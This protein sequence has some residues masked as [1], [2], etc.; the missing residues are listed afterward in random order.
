[1][2]WEVRTMASGT[3]YFNCT[4]YRKTMGRFWPLW[5]LWGVLWML[6][7]P[8]NG[9]SRYID[10]LAWGENANSLVYH[11]T[12]I[13][14]SRSFGVWA[15][16]LFGLLAAMAAFSYLYSQ[17]SAC[18]MHALPIRREGL[19]FSQYLA[20]LT[21]LLLP[22]AVVALAALGVELAV[23][24]SWGWSQT[25]PA[26]GL[27]L[28]CMGGISLFFYSFACFCAMFT[29]HLLALP[30]FYGILNVLASGV[31]FL[32]VALMQQFLYGFQGRGVPLLVELAT[33]LLRLTG[34]CGVYTSSS[35][36]S[37]GRVHILLSL[38]SPGD[39]AGYAAAGVALAL[40]ALW[41]YKSRQV[42][43]AGDVVSVPL[44]RPV[45][46]YGVAFC[47]G[48]CLGV[49]TVSLLGW[50][51]GDSAAVLVAAILLWTAAGFFAAE[52]LLKKTF[53][54]FRAWRGCVASVAVMAFL[55][56]VCV[57]DLF[58]VETRLPSLEQVVRM[59]VD[60]DI[61]YPADSGRL[62]AVTGDPAVIQPVLELQRAIV[63]Q[64]GRAGTE[65]GDD[66][67]SL[68]V[69]Y[70]LNGGGT[71]SRSYFSVPVFREELE[72]EGS[73]TWQAARLLGDR[74]LT[75][76][77][78][79][80][81]RCEEGRLAE[82]RLEDVLD[83]REGYGVSLYLEQSTAELLELWQ[84]VRQDFQEGNLGAHTLFLPE[85]PEDGL[86]TSTGWG[87]WPSL[88]FYWEME[89]DSAQA[90]GEASAAV[91]TQR[92]EIALSPQAE[93]TLAWMEAHH[94]PGEGYALFWD[95]ET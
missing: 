55:C 23:V 69:T 40:L 12:D 58:G 65:A 89:A 54:V 10:W 59:E 49:F 42:E 76:Q 34:A 30:V 60:A 41:V 52:M 90:A 44:V 57:F 35:T 67:I 50:S 94:V 62:E 87:M 28:A 24:P 1:M 27:W 43:S 46:K 45:F 74:A 31:N 56:A 47:A 63:E 73:V 20:G 71:M 61:G 32:V 3:S 48:L 78:Y 86:E 6:V 7:I 38:D 11:F 72:R 70:T 66:Y 26:L 39:V 4:L 51:S 88:Y 77:M 75:G 79:G 93:H 13:P 15:G 33:P 2:N 8:L 14:H 82:V 17:R 16:A 37:S 83:L 81:A 85:E 25:L 36:D 68:R 95:E 64:R 84:A 19:F 80:F 91:K 21:M 5:T 29:G 9:L 53:R 18:M 22:L 92:L